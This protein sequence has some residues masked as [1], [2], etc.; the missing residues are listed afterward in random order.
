MDKKMPALRRISTEELKFQP[1]SWY[2][3]ISMQLLLAGSALVICVM[4]DSLGGV[5]DEGT[6]NGL[7][8]F[9]GRYVQYRFVVSCCSCD[10]WCWWSIE[11]RRI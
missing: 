10:T 3:F 5:T 7:S 1:T 9:C 6:S 4:S 11:I 2:S 8:T